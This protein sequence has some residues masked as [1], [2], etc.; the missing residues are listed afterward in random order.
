MSERTGG[1]P[2]ESGADRSVVALTDYDRQ[3]ATL[4]VAGWRGQLLAVSASVFPGRS[5][6]I[7]F[8]EQH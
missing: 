3:A 8:V 7:L 1:C 5:L 2:I 6:V 4:A